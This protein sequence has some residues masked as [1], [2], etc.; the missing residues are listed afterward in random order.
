[1]LAQYLA[2]VQNLLQLPGAPA[3]LYSTPNLTLW[4]NIARGQIAGESRCIRVLGTI[5][6][7]VGQRAYNFSSI[8]TGTVS[9]TGI[10][11]VIAME[12][13]LYGVGTGMKWVKNKAWPWF[14]YY[15]MN[16]PAPVTGYPTEWTQFTPG[17]AGQGS[18]TGV[19]TGTMGSGNFYL[20]PPPDQVYTLTCDCIG[21]PQALASDTDVEALTYLWTDA[22]P[23][24]AAYL[25]L[26][27]A[28]TGERMQQAQAMKQLY[29][30]FVQRA[31]SFANP[32][33]NR[34][35]YDQSGDPFMA[36]RL[37]VQTRGGAGG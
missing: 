12:N 36:N 31:R 3:S 1:M 9:T 2:N 19:G 22:V 4:L 5:Q 8:N 34:Y 20:D 32:A 21:Y 24:F 17:S 25:A 30:E 7:I 27:S 35:L 28:Q 18:I 26:M 11:G 23:Y 33:V 16:N 37:G 15:R 29:E 14:L 13:M 10:Q 6:T